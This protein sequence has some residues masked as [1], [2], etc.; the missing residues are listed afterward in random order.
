MT[1]SGSDGQPDPRFQQLKDEARK[2]QDEEQERKQ[3]REHK[4]SEAD[5]RRLIRKLYKNVLAGIGERTYRLAVEAD[6]FKAP[7]LVRLR[8]RLAP[9]PIELD[10]FSDGLNECAKKYAPFVKQFWPEITLAAGIFL[11]FM[12]LR[13]VTREIV[14]EI[15]ARSDA[16]SAEP[17]E[18]T[19]KPAAKPAARKTTKKK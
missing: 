19:E 6:V 9:E 3:E 18:H 10:T 8:K 14:E 1:S 17:V 5:A 12:R 16:D 11:P 4:F 13:G 7:D 15:R 2:T